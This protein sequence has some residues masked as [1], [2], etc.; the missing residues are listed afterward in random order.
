MCGQEILLCWWQCPER[1]HR[2]HPRHR[3]SSLRLEAACF[4]HTANRAGRHL[5][6]WNVRLDRFHDTVVDPAGHYGW[7]IRRDI[8]F[9][10]CLPVELGRDQR[11]PDM[12]MLAQSAATRQG[13][14]TPAAVL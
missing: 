5:R 4:R 8:H 14:W 7:C 2:Y 11:R 6:A 3:T 12:R 13:H 10:G 1:H 9:Q